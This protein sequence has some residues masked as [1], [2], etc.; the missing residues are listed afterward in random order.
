MSLMPVPPE[1]TGATCPHCSAPIVADQ[2]YC[3]TC[4][5]PVAPVRLAF[6]DVLQA[7]GQV[8][9]GRPLDP[10][11]YG[12]G[13]D[14]ERSPLLRWL[15]RYS[16]VFGVLT[17]LLL[18]IL[19]GLLVGHWATAGNGTPGKQVVEVKGLPTIAAS[20][21]GGT[22]TTAAPTSTGAGKSTA[23]EEAEEAKE[24]KEEEKKAAKVQSKTVKVSPSAI[25]KLQSTG[26]KQHQEE[27]NKLGAQPIETGG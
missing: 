1:Q 11:D 26:G 4:G 12:D 8:A 15:R 2:R 16:G 6:L 21:A 19:A 17:V 3:L 14:G 20:P 27:L 5:Q 9:A 7:E 23:A 22:A 18:A 13:R 25:K 10:A 24:A